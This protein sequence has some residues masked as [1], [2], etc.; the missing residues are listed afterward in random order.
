VGLA[1]PAL[2]P[3]TEGLGVMAQ[4]VASRVQ[5]QGAHAPG[6]RWI[7]RANVGIVSFQG[8]AESLAVRHSLYTFDLSD[9][10]SPGRP[11]VVVDAA[12]TAGADETMP[13]VPSEGDPP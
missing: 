5:W 13:V 11:Y 8:A 4:S 2:R 12:L 6:R 7:P 9:P 1:P 3:V 10:A